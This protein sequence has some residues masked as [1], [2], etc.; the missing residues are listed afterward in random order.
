[1]FVDAHDWGSYPKNFAIK[2]RQRWFCWVKVQSGPRI[3][4]V[5]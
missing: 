3:S 2:P 4:T 5:K 1:M